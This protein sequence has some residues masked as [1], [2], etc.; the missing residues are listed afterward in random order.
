MITKDYLTKCYADLQKEG[1]WN[2]DVDIFKKNFLRWSL[3]NHPDKNL[4]NED[5]TKLYQII[6]G[7]RNDFLENFQQYSSI[8]KN[9]HVDRPA[10]YNPLE[11]IPCPVC[12]KKVQRWRMGDHIRSAHPS[13]PKSAPKKSKAK[14]SKSNTKRKS[15]PK[16][17]K[18]KKSK[19]SKKSKSKKSAPKKSKK[20]KKSKKSKKTKKSKKSVPKKTKK[21]K[22]S[23]PKKTKKTKKSKKSVPK[24]TKKSKKSAP[25]KSAPKKSKAV[26]K[27]SKK[28]KTKKS[29]SKGK[30]QK[31]GV[32]K[33]ATNPHEFKKKMEKRVKKPSPLR[34]ELKVERP[35]SPK[36][37]RKRTKSEPVQEVPEWDF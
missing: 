17:S 32:G 25:K 26:P 20:T 29:K 19:K 9:Q 35:Q 13:G 21:S 22:K 12:Q 4:G 27:K 5:I 23:A 3:K 16:K 28:S 8:A 15:A 10:F 7:C 30:K 14:K 18:A 34:N 33:K 31:G 11:E 24:K 2:D 37:K 1:I 6:S 36:L